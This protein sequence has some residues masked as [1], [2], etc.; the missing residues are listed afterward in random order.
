MREPKLL[1][2]RILLV[3]LLL[4][5]V[6]AGAAVQ[7]ILAVS[8]GTELTFTAQ[9][10]DP[11]ALLTGHY[12]QVTY[13]ISRPMTDEELAIPSSKSWQPVWVAIVPNEGDW[14]VAS[15]TAKKPAAAPADGRLVAAEARYLSGT[16]A[17]LRYGIERIY[18]QQKEA[19]A[20]SNAVRGGPTG[21][22][23]VQV[24][25]SL[26]KDGRLRIKAIIVD[27]TRT[28]FTWW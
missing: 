24:V 12:A 6:L 7:H 20:I 15:I 21:D 10:F 11:R 4:S 2:L 25:A 23:K 9:A 8:S 14:K 22:S 17:R 3:G 28:D 26:G 19:E 16:S 5:A 13:A 18:A 1:T 27:G